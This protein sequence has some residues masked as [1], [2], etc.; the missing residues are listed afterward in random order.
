MYG[1]KALLTPEQIQQLNEIGF[2][3]SSGIKTRPDKI[4]K[5]ENDADEDQNN[6]I[7]NQHLHVQEEEYV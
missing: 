5:E 4:R 1:K 7:L 2:R 3:W 6:E